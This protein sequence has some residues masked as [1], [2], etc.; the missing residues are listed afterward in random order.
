MPKQHFLTIDFGT[1]GI[2]CMVFST[3]GTALARQFTPIQYVDTEGLFGI[4]KEF[5]AGEVWQTICKM[6]PLV[7]K[8]SKSQPVDISSI[9]A[10]SQRHGAVFLDKKGAVIYS[11]PNLDARGVFMQD[12][13]IDGLEEACPPT[14]CWPPLLYS[15]CRLLWFKKEKPEDF[16]KIEHVLSISDWIVYQLTGQ[17]TTDPTQASNTQLMD[18]QSSQWSP[19]ILEMAE[20]SDEFL[21]EIFDPGTV[22]GHITSE[23]GKSTGLSTSSLVGIGGAD[24]QCALLGSS[25]TSAGEVGIVSGNTGPVQLVT[26]EPIIDPDNRL[27]TGRFLIPQKWVLEANSG[28]NGSVLNWYVQNI[29]AP[30]HPEFEGP[31]EQAFTHVE[32]L[33][34]QSPIGS[35]DTIALLGPQ[36][37]DA[38]DMTTVRPSFFIFPPP[39]SPAVTPISINEITR[40]LFENICY[41]SRMNLER[42]QELAQCEFEHCVVAGGLTRSAFFRQ[43][44]ADVTGLTI[45]TGQVVEASSL[46][47]AICAAT[48]AGLHGSLTDAIPV[49]VKMRPDL[50]PREDVHNQYKTYFTRW[51]TL[52]NQSANL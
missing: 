20:L 15:L 24:T 12:S 2:K 5:D 50:Q 8:E 6:I 40:A 41:A 28:P 9:G 27:W 49:M 25:I 42:I 23:A 17:A 43:M 46:G 52:Y 11:G 35:F 10:T 26:A 39:T 36:I 22:V 14:G 47:A 21:P 19:E 45:R 31:T 13:V 48:A 1:S 7:L 30:L 34:S 3:E 44:L 29:V 33:A 32:Q 18:I 16:S 51:L 4:G 38:S 37:M